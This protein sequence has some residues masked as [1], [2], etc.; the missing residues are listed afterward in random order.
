MAGGRRLTALCAACSRHMTSHI[1]ERMYSMRQDMK[2]TRRGHTANLGARLH[3]SVTH[4]RC[5]DQGH[6]LLGKRGHTHE[7]M[8][9]RPLDML[10]LKSSGLFPEGHQRIR[11]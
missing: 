3:M 2:G 10:S 5:Q 1:R 9:I 7:K 4:L 11:A 8:W 6:H